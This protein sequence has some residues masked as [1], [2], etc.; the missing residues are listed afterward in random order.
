MVGFQ[1][2][3]VDREGEVGAGLELVELALH[4]DR[5][6]A[7]VDELAAVDVAAHDFADVVVNQG[8]AAGDRDDGRAAFLDR[9]PALLG[10]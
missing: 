9:V 8:L 4:Q 3:D 1:T 2:V 7:E 10:G 6:G 5:V